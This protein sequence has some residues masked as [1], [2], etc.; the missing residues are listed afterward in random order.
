MNPE[1]TATFATSAG[2]AVTVKAAFVDGKSLDPL[3]TIK[4]VENGVIRRRPMTRRAQLAEFVVGHENFARAFV[5]RLWGWFF[6][7]G[8]GERPELDD[9][10]PH[11]KLFCPELLERLAKDFVVSGYQPRFLMRSICNSQAYQLSSA[12]N[13]T[14]DGWGAYARKLPPQVRQPY[15]SRMGL[16][17]MTPDQ[18]VESLLTCT[19]SRPDCVARVSDVDRKR[20]R[21]RLAGEVEELAGC[22][23]DT[24]V[25]ADLALWLMN[26]KVIDELVAATQMPQTGV[27]DFAKNVDA[28]YL[29]TLN[30]QPAKKE[31]VYLLTD[32]KPVLVKEKSPF[33]PAQDLLWALINS[34][35]FILNH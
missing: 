5:H 33:A 3:R 20:L 35:E 10:G 8:L 30:R 19:V 9:L 28:L 22:M 13:E 34:S 11:N 1:A 14:N 17:M 27:D 29:A 23:V 15:F 12:A 21:E 6:G 24:F 4:V 31:V 7:R 26:G 2:T 25:R 16:K 18:F 32:L